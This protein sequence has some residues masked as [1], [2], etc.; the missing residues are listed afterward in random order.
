MFV[1]LIYWQG[2]AAELCLKTIRLVI[3]INFDGLVA[4]CS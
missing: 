4:V 3:L 2:F 1:G